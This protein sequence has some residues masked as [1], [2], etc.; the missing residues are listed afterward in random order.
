M[1]RFLTIALLAGAAIPAAAAAQDNERGRTGAERREA[2]M[3]QRAE[4]PAFQRTE[5]AERAERPAFQR[6]ERAERPAFQRLDRAP[7]VDR[8]QRSFTPQAVP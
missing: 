6:P 5:R 8:Q 4:R 2:M 7:S 3:A 1:I